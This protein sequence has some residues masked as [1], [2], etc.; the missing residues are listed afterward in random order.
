MAEK[1][2]MNGVDTGTLKEMAQTFQE[3]PE[4][5]QCQFKVTNEWDN[6]GHNETTISEFHAKGEDIQH[7]APF[8]LEAD[9]P[10]LLLGTD[11]G[12]NPVEHMLNA[13]VSCLTTSMVYHAAVQGIQI[14]ELESTVEGELDMRGFMG[15]S[16]DVPKGYKNIKVSFRAK[17]DGDPKQLKTCALYSPVFNTITQGADIDVDVETT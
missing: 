1:Q 5:A 13:L 11:K 14:D 16:S 2:M 6:C 12:P 8:T 17:S 15:I 3:N 10:P 9:E 7:E 4:L